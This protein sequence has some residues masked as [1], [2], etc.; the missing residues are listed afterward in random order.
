MERVEGGQ[1]F[2]SPQ[3]GEM[4]VVSKNLSPMGTD[5][6]LPDHPI[7]LLNLDHDYKVTGRASTTGRWL[8]S[9]LFYTS[10]WQPC[11]DDRSMA[12]V[13]DVQLS[14]RNPKETICTRLMKGA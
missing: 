9:L 7:F 13:S 2:A 5:D 4:A 3:S 11:I 12:V 10:W 1:A 8:L 14:K 6:G